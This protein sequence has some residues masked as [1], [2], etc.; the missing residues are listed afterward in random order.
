MIQKKTAEFGNFLDH[1][2]TPPRKARISGLTLETT[3]FGLKIMMKSGV[4]FFITK[5]NEPLQRYLITCQANSVFMGWFFYT[6]PQ[7]LWSCLFNFKIKKKKSRPLFTNN[8]KPKMS[9]S[10]FDILVNKIII[11]SH[12]WK[13]FSQWKSRQL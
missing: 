9:I 10:R 13:N 3:I 6:G 8:F 4:E 7:Q 11:L 12:F 2:N 5:L 1:L